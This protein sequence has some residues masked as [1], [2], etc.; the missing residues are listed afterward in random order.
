MSEMRSV[1]G[2][3]GLVIVGGWPALAMPSA[4]GLEEE[5]QWVQRY[6]CGHPIPRQEAF[7]DLSPDASL[8]GYRFGGSALRSDHRVP[9]SIV[10]AA[11]TAG[12]MALETFNAVVVNRYVGPLSS[13]AWH[14]DDEAKCARNDEGQVRAI[15]SLS[16]G[17]TR[18]FQLRP[19]ATGAGG[20]RKRADIV[21]LELRHGEML[22]ML[23]GCQEMFEH[24]LVKV[25]K[26]SAAGRDIG[27]RINLT[28]RVMSG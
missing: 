12:T 28:F 10:K 21:S 2:T 22:I 4:R 17:E 20:K 13:V 5:V 8:G 19:K 26:K 11:G 6:M 14:S 16:L 15:A 27:T 18:T 23:P 24:R 9:D 25:S 1:P 7:F 3:K